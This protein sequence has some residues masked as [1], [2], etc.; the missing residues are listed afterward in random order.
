M[1]AATR[2]TDSGV[3]SALS[4]LRCRRGSGI[5]TSSSRIGMSRVPLSILP[6]AAL[7]SS[8]RTQRLLIETADMTRMT[9]PRSSDL[10]QRAA[11]QGCHRAR[12]PIC[13]ARAESPTLRA[14]GSTARRKTPCLRWHA[15]QR[16]SGHVA[17]SRPAAWW[18]CP[19]S[20]PSVRRRPRGPDVETGAAFRRA[21]FAR[22]GRACLVKVERPT[23]RTTWTRQARSGCLWCAAGG[24]GSAGLP[25]LARV[26]GRVALPPE[27][28][29][30]S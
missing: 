28:G 16:R 17:H 20:E 8:S 14:S 12:S 2:S 18:H 25:G 4:H 22:P 23:G 5:S 6:T 13:R 1:S 26:Q 29:P 10:H 27:A 24:S 15:T 30:G 21:G 3:R 11:V 9:C 19:R 7:S